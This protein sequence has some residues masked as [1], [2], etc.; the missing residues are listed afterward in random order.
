[1]WNRSHAL[2]TLVYLTQPPLPKFSLYLSRTDAPVPFL[3]QILSRLPVKFP[4]AV[5]TSLVDRTLKRILS[6]VIKLRV[7]TCARPDAPTNRRILV[8]SVRISTVRLGRGPEARHSPDRRSCIQL[9]AATPW[10]WELV[11]IYY[12]RGKPV[13]SYIFPSE[14]FEPEPVSTTAS[15]VLITRVARHRQAP[16]DT[17]TDIVAHGTLESYH[18]NAH[19]PASTQSLA[20]YRREFCRKLHGYS[21]VEREKKRSRRLHRVRPI[22]ENGI[23]IGWWSSI[24]VTKKNILCHGNFYR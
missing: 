19:T 21:C 10:Q 22:F 16:A 17:F 20:D 9:T 1:M 18:R 6:T 7:G 23:P 11:F 24:W 2:P 15:D 5:L 3:A 8:R 14:L 4:H 12:S 13:R